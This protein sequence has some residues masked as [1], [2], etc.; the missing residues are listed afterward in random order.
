MIFL[1]IFYVFFVTFFCILALR[2]FAFH[3]GLLDIPNER[4][5]HQGSVP[6]IGGIAMFAGVSF[7]LIFSEI[8]Y[9]ETKYN[10]L[11]LSSFIILCVG[12]FDDYKNISHKLRF[13][14]QIIVA[15]IITYF[16]DVSLKNLGGL[17]FSNQIIYLDEFSILFSV[18]AILGV[19]NSLNFSDGIDGMC[20][21]LSLITFLSVGF[22]GILAGD[23]L[24]INIVLCFIT[25]IA[26]FLVFN[27][28]LG[29]K[30]RFKIFMG[31]AGSTFLGL[32][33]A[34]V[35]IF[36]TQG[37]DSIFS[38]V[39]ALWIYAVPLIDTSSIMIRRISK[40]KSPFSPDRGHLHHFFIYKGFSE[41]QALLL[42]IIMAIAMALIG[43]MLE[44]N[45]F[46]EN[47]MF[48]LFIFLSLTYHVVLKRAWKEVDNEQ[49]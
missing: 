39:T 9:I 1:L 44:I 16:G 6:L 24:A 37:A 35:L 47:L 18:F 3:F 26:A 2:P 23:Y 43:V 38:P 4:K 22:F 49:T 7:G 20:A 5:I 29:N 27:V 48:Y 30:S 21:S 46:P 19:L 28:G 8:I 10:L 41:K 13:L 42:I 34:W 33:I 14:I 36:Y 12:V 11:I 17:F 32:A 15:L 40:R 31:D 45:D 25:S